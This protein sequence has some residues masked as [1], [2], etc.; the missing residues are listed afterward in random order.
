MP[1]RP[2]A[3]P[4]RHRWWPDW[5]ADDASNT[6]IFT[7]GGPRDE[8][9][10]SQWHHTSG[11]VPDEDDLHR[12][13]SGPATL[14]P[15]KAGTRCPGPSSAHSSSGVRRVG[16]AHQ[17]GQ[18]RWVVNR[19]IHDDEV[20]PEGRHLA[21]GSC[22]ARCNSG[23]RDELP[24]VRRPPPHWRQDRQSPAG[25][26]AGASPCVVDLGTASSTRS[27]TPRL[28]VCDV[29]RCG[30]RRASPRGYGRISTHRAS[31]RADGV[32]GVSPRGR[33]GRRARRRRAAAAPPAARSRARPR[34]WR[35]APPGPRRR[36]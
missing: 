36:R 25:S 13:P 14:P 24:P 6:S 29:H 8:L 9:D 10:I 27:P 15:S 20:R 12:R 21:G 35:P 23:P 11:S 19:Q 4:F 16:A 3:A 26:R 28:H 18:Q 32:T 17:R 2:A 7:T 33:W 34:W 5:F 30:K 22:A 1:R 31:T